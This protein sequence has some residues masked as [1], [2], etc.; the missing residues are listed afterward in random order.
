MRGA[1]GAAV[2]TRDE[3]LSWPISITGPTYGTILSH[4]G[5]L[6][7]HPP[8][9]VGEYRIGCE[10]IIIYAMA[11]TSTR[12]RR[13]RYSRPKSRSRIRRRRTYRRRTKSKVPTKF[14]RKKRPTSFKLFDNL[15]QK[16]IRTSLIYCDT[17]YI[18]PT[19][20][21]S[22]WRYSINGLYDVDLTGGGHQP[23]HY[24]DWTALYEQYRVIAMRFKVTFMPKRGSTSHLGLA[25]NS[26]ADSDAYNQDTIPCIVGWEANNDSSNSPLHF[27]PGDKNAIRET[28]IK[29]P[30]LHGWTHTSASPYR[31]YTFTGTISL[32]DIYNDKSAADEMTGIG[33][34]P[35]RRA[36]IFFCVMSKDGSTTSGWEIDLKLEYLSEF[37][38]PSFK[39]PA[40]EN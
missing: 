20:T 16:R 29:N 6:F 10:G 17:K 33:A 23:L 12:R 5:H 14:Y 28:R 39:N 30:K 34:N 13:R 19:T 9:G 7:R 32:K 27:E 26:V 40:N 18:G 1:P 15:F 25:G 38:D 8:R 36:N 22:F 21:T 24:D 37:S 3:R 2:F 35:N 11:Y 31:T 4:L